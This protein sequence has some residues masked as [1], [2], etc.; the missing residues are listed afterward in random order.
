MFLQLYIVIFFYIF[1]ILYL[2]ITK[3]NDNKYL[4]GKH[5]ICIKYQIKEL[6]LDYVNI[7]YININGLYLMNLFFYIDNINRIILVRE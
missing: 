4:R 7:Y 2:K 6:N 1:I 5:I 3:N